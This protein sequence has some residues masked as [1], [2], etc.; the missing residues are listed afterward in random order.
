MK[1]PNESFRIR[2]RAAGRA[3][4]KFAAAINEITGSILRS[5]FFLAPYQPLLAASKKLP[6]DLVLPLL[7]LKSTTYAFAGA[8]KTS[9]TV[10]LG[11]SGR[12]APHPKA[13]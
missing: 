13:C 12:G 8:T 10:G 4:I 9:E 2:F 5:A 7:V 3:L 11:V 1:G 6:P